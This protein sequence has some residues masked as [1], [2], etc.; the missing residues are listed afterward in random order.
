MQYFILVINSIE[1]IA[2]II[3]PIIGEIRIR[4]E[5][6]TTKVKEVE[7]TIMETTITEGTTIIMEEIIKMDIKVRFM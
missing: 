5:G 7:E 6:A 1:I 4:E 2:E 3:I